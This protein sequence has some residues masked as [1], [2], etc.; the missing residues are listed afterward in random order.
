MCFL[1]GKIALLFLMGGLFIIAFSIFQIV[2]SK[3]QTKETLEKAEKY[4]EEARN[5]EAGETKYVN[6]EEQLIGILRVPKLHASL[7]IIEGTDE[8]ELEKGVGHYNGTALPEEGEQI[9][10]SGHRD[11]VFRNFDKLEIGDLFIV[12]LPDGTYTYEILFTEVVDADDTTVIGSKG[13]E[14]LT[15][16]TCYPFHYIGNAPERFIF[17]AYPV[18]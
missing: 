15:V 10:L 5:K 8:Q 1:R 13:E 14:V 4:I 12:E 2:S 16:T 17:Y 3:Q 9:V 7:P 6:N 18:N 11:T